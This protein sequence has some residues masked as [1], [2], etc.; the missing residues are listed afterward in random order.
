MLTL[1]LPRWIELRKVN[2]AV[3]SSMT[4]VSD[5]EHYSKPDYWEQADS[6]EAGGKGDCEDYALAKCRRLVALGWPREALRIATCWDEKGEYHAVL[7]VDT[8]EG[9]WVL[10]NR[11]L[12]I[13]N[14]ADLPYR[15][16]KREVPGRLEWAKIQSEESST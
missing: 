4:Y 1:T 10:D 12:G 14:F 3:D 6:V 15:W 2:N 11:Q 16:D 8:A 9:T 7:T 5:P 13:L